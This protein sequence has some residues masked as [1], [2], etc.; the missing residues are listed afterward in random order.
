MRRREFIGALVATSGWIVAARGQT[1][2]L[3]RLGMASQNPRNAPFTAAFEQ[4]LR[5][6][7]YVEGQNLAVEFID[8]K[9]EVERIGEAMKAL[10]QR[11]VDILMAGGPEASLRAALAAT[12]TLPIVMI[13]IDYDP[14]A[15]GYVQSLARPGEHVTGIYFQQTELAGKR[16]QLMKEA[17]PNLRAATVFWDHFSQD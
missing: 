1:R 3:L 2:K 5:E 13:A 10:V 14:F 15:L 7:G 17:L 12:A 4:R 8:T 6:L 9:G 11:N 16:L